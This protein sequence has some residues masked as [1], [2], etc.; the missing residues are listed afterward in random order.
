[1]GA[2]SGLVNLLLKPYSRVTTCYH[3]FNTKVSGSLRRP[4]TTR[5]TDKLTRARSV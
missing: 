3:V 5:L 4:L 2:R 1:M